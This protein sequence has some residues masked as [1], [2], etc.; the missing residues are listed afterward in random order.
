MDI[1]A[2]LLA[3]KND[4]NKYRAHARNMRTELLKIQAQNNY[5][6]VA[7]DKQREAHYLQLSRLNKKH[8]DLATTLDSYIRY[9]KITFTQGA[10]KHDIEYINKL[11]PLVIKGS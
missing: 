10:N 2:K 4:L 11:M 1:N 6:K 7:L 9:G 3:M 8:I 5:L